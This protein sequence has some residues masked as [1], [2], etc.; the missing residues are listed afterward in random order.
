[1][2]KGFFF[3]LEFFGIIFM[4]LIPIAS[5]LYIAIYELIHF[6]HPSIES[7]ILSGKLPLLVMLIIFMLE[8][9]IHFTFK[10]QQKKILRKLGIKPKIRRYKIGF[11]QI[12]EV[13]VASIHCIIKMVFC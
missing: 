2:K 5:I 1:M 7:F 6:F 11:G 10:P 12:F 4:Y 13:R 3:L 8:V 9:I